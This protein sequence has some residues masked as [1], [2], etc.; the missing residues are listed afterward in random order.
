M[1][2]NHVHTA[3]ETQTLHESALLRRRSRNPFVYLWQG[4]Q[5][6]AWFFCPP[7]EDP[8]VYCWLLRLFLIGATLG[9]VLTYWSLK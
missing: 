2:V 3:Q 4:W 9:S 1:I 8:C 7:G 5:H 6:F